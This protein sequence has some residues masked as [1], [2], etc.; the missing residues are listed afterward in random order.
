MHRIKRRN[1]HLCAYV[2]SIL[3]RRGHEVELEPAPV[4]AAGHQYGF[5]DNGF[6]WLLLLYLPYTR[7]HGQTLPRL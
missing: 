4:E 7:L 2:K 5:G 1:T 6:T 3:L